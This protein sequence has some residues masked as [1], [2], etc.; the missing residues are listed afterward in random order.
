M[1]CYIDQ[2]GKSFYAVRLP[3]KRS[4]KKDSKNEIIVMDESV[5]NR[6]LFLDAEINNLRAELNEYEKAAKEAIENRQKPADLYDWGY[7][8]KYGKPTQFM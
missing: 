1:T 8:D 3:L 6:N 5:E 7:I 4:K 2:K